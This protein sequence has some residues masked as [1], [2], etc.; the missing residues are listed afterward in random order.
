MTRVNRERGVTLVE[1]LVAL[2]IMGLV[3]TSILVLVGQNTRFTVAAEDRAYAAIAADNLMVHAL[4]ISG[5]L[6]IGEEL[7]ETETASRVW[8]YRRTISETGV[9]S[10]VRIDIAVFADEAEIENAQVIGS[11]TSLRRIDQ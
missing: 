8:R 4:A 2:A 3:T 5:P 9:S 6:E 1:T 10:I 7:G 11:A